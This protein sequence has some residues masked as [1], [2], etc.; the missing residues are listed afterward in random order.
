[1]PCIQQKIRIQ[2]KKPQKLHKPVTL[3]QEEK[4]QREYVSGCLLILD[5]AVKNQMSYNKY[6]H[7]TKRKAS[8]KNSMKGMM[9]MTQMT[10]NR[11]KNCF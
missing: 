9:A 11:D 1:M 2:A 6:V 3:S 4:H 8:L 7:R 5:L 10:E